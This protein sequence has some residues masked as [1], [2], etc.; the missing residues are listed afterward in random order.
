MKPT[1]FLSSMLAASF[2]LFTHAGCAASDSNTA[3]TNDT[4]SEGQVTSEQEALFRRRRPPRPPMGT[5]GM[6]SGTGGSTSTGTCAAPTGNL[7]AII[8]AAQTPDGRAI[9]Q[10]SLPGGC[11]PKVVAALGFWSCATL[12]DACMYSSSG[13]THHCTCN[14]VDGEGQLPAWVCD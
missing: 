5:A 10:A 8:A 3:L 14:R 1:H 12:G 4:A 9:P 13:T 7:D 6:A 11:C 2:L